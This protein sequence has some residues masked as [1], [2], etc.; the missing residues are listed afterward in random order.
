MTQFAYGYVNFSGSQYRSYPNTYSVCV[1]MC[2]CILKFSRCGTA[3]KIKI[4]KSFHGLETVACRKRLVLTMQ[5]C[6]LSQLSM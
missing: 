3:K 2:V 5:H 6:L 4:Y 1:C